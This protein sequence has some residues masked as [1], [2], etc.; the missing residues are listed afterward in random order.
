MKNSNF[1]GNLLLCTGIGSFIEFKILYYKLII[2]SFAVGMDLTIPFSLINFIT[3]YLKSRERESVVWWR[4]RDTR[5]TFYNRVTEIKME[6]F[7]K[8][9]CFFR[10]YWQ[11]KIQKVSKWHQHFR[12][13]SKMSHLCKLYL[14][15]KVLKIFLKIHFSKTVFYNLR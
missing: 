6:H 12:L 3:L 1:L 10:S 2:S 9:P 4:T 15:Q 5:A 8:S 11:K 7:F 14:R 13:I